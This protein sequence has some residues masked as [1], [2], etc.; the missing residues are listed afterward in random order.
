MNNVLVDLFPSDIAGIIESFFIAK[1][2][3]F[4][5]NHLVR[6]NLSDV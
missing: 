3:E 2:G 6:A 4:S 1:G 5:D